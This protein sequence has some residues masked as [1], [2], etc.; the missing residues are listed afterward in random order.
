MT[1]ASAPGPLAADPVCFSYHQTA[2]N[3]TVPTC[4]CPGLF[5]KSYG[6][7]QAWTKPAERFAKSFLRWTL[8]ETFEGLRVKNE[9]GG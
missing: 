7:K 5:R 3:E 8:P 9:I 2:S 4:F 1:E 6:H